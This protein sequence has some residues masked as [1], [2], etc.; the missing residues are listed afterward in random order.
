[1]NGLQV[2]V[3]SNLYLEEV[4]YICGDGVKEEELA[5]AVEPAF[6]PPCN[7][8]GGE[9]VRLD[10]HL[11]RAGGFPVTDQFDQSQMKDQAWE[12]IHDLFFRDEELL[13]RDEDSRR[14]V[15]PVGQVEIETDIQ[16]MAGVAV[17]IPFIG[18]TS[19]FIPELQEFVMTV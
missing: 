10:D 18:K 5:E 9:C 15:V 16:S 4:F 19:K 8:V 13:V 7:L 12:E 17:V 14:K 11:R 1:M 2:I 6:F 3:R